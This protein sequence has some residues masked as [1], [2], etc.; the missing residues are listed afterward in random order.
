MQSP[1]VSWA[2]VRSPI[3][4]EW[5]PENGTFGDA[6]ENS[7]LL[8]SPEPSWLATAAP[9]L[10]LEHSTPSASPCLETMQKPLLR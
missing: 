6:P 5:G 8:G 10:Q 2:Q 4:K 7:E 1:H 9:S 3:E